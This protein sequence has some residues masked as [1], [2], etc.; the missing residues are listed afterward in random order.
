MPQRQGLS[1]KKRRT[2]LKMNVT[3]FHD[4]KSE[5]KRAEHLVYVSLKYTRTV[6]VI[7]SI[8]DRLVSCYD[9]LISSLLEE[10]I[11]QGKIERLPTTAGGKVDLLRKLYSDNPV[12]INNLDF[13]S[14]L[15]KLSLAKFD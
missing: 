2:W 1:L 4:A 15:R 6:D 10:A 13:Y 3:D 9:I 12:I 14:I 7:K 8:I 5:L 11:A